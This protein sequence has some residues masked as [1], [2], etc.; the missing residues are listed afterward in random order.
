MS[1][2]ETF[3]NVVAEKYR[4]NISSEREIQI[5]IMTAFI[6]GI[7]YTMADYDAAVDV[8]NAFDP[9]GVL[10]DG[11]SRLNDVA[12]AETYEES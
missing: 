6:H 5:A 12:W 11:L 9:D 1:D 7:Y 10:S 3:L 4:N 8:V 2:I